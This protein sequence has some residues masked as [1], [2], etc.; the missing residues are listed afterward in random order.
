MRLD[1]K[2]MRG[3]GGIACGLRRDDRATI[4]ILAAGL[5]FVICGLAAAAV[6]LG[7]VFW[8]RHELQAAADAAALAGTFDL[9]RAATIA[10]QSAATNGVGASASIT[11]VT[12]T[13]TGDPTLSPANRFAAGGSTPNALRVTI[14]QAV[15]IFF[16]RIFL[17]RT[18][19]P[20][21]VTATAANIA[22]GSFSAG[23]G[24]ATLNAGVLNSLLTGLLGGTVSLSLINYQALAQGDI[25][26]LSFCGALATRLG[27]TGGTYGALLA[28]AVTMGDIIAAAESVAGADDNAQAVAALTALDTSAVAMQSVDLGA[29]LDLGSWD[30]R[31]IGSLNPA[32]ETAPGINLLD[33]LTLGAEVAAGGHLVTVN[34]PVSISGITSASLSL[35]VGESAQNAPRIGLGPVG[36]SI[37][38]AQIRFYFLFDLLP[39]LGSVVQLPL[40]IEAAE[41]TATLSAITC[42]SDPATDAV[43]TI[44]G[45]PGL[46]TSY[47]AGVTQSQMTN[48]TTPVTPG[49]GTIVTVPL[50]ATIKADVA[51]TLAAPSPS[52]VEFSDQDIA[53]ATVRTL[54]TT[55]FTAGLLAGLSNSIGASGGLTVTLLGL[56]L[57]LGLLT[58]GLTAA[59]QAAVPAVDPLVNSVL[60]SLGIELGTMEL[61]ATGVR[62]GIPVIVQ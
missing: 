42:S 20:V 35:A 58:S 32:I 3:R 13:Y 41:G 11:A 17:N 1:Q 54:S 18:S 15:P 8:L 55:D 45:A 4:S 10:A 31:Q 37:H 22:E 46:A 28:S 24:L 57:Q 50:L 9:S 59:L 19:V 61:R 21:E 47:I 33:L 27:V 36:I 48:F 6:D 5:L 49:P 25:S 16:L 51:A 14:E 60:S 40:Y 39:I 44:S 23:T 62:C 12:G 7:S 38:T 30:L 29:L 43:M 53:N 52:D 2:L 56:P 34:L 26:L